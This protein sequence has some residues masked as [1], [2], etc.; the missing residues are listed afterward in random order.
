MVSEYNERLGNT[1]SDMQNGNINLNDAMNKLQN[2][3][4]EYNSW[5]TA[6]D[7]AYKQRQKLI[8]E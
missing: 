4:R 3:R 1:I 2:M 5:G 6:V 8:E 7:A